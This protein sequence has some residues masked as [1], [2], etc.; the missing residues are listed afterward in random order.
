M[1]EFDFKRLQALKGSGKPYL[2]MVDPMIVDQDGDHHL[3]LFAV[4]N[5][6][7]FRSLYNMFG[8]QA[9]LYRMNESLETIGEMAQGVSGIKFYII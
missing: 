4:S 7:E 9:K 2:T 8:H 3:L 5:R 1:Q 6:K